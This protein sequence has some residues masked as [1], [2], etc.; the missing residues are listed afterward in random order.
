MTMARHDG[1]RRALLA[2]IGAAVC[3]AL[4]GIA[5]A[6]VWPERPIRMVVPFAAG[7]GSD[8]VGRVIALKL[9]EALGQQVV[10]ENRPGAGGSIGAAQVV[11]A[12]PD[13]YTLLLGSTSEIAQYPNVSPNVPY[14][15]QRDFTPVAL[16]ATVPLVLT[17]SE[18]LP[19][20]TTQELIDYARK[21]P[22]KLNYG[23]AGTGS[24]TH[25][26]MALFTHMSKT[27][28][29]NVPYKG[30]APVV[31]DLLA[32]NLDLAMPT[33]SAVL[34]HAESGKL[35]LLAVS[36]GKPAAAL[37]KLPTIGSSVNGY[38]T[39]LWTGLLAPPGTPQ[40]IVDRL[41]KAIAT[42]LKSPD[43]QKILL[44]QGAEASLGS[45][46]EFAAQIKSEFAVWKEVVAETGIRISK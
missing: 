9:T 38:A 25:L 24:T 33:M 44:T 39:G 1:G 2:A 22:G 29:T 40:P 45:P 5:A 27:Q 41:Y 20:K 23:S 32:G 42:A 12:P 15:P 17:V 7:G 30:S 10:V 36:T 14:D 31:T 28:M 46:A 26:G 11:K 19:V 43:V 16:I 18:K 4:P 34:P 13:G 8:S 6:Q 37:P 35:R 3:F 21:N